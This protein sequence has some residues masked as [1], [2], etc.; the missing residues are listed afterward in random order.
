MVVRTWRGATRA[1]DADA[2]AEYIGET[3]I[4]ALAGTAGNRGVQMWQRVERDRAEFVVVSWWESR[5]AIVAFAVE[6]IERAVFYPEDDRYLVE[7]GETV[8][9]YD[10]VREA[11]A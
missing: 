9:H 6:P 7:R 3:G 4:A 8:V 11:R 5:E 10:V 1:A 2:Y